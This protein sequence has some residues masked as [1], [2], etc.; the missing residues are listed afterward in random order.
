MR[1]VVAVALILGLIAGHA[2]GP[3]RAASV[4]VAVLGEQFVDAAGQPVFVVGANYE[5]PADRAWQMWDEG[6]FDAELIARDFERARA[7]DLTVLRVFVQQSLANDVRAGRWAKLDRVLELADG[8]GLKL[9][10]TFAD[11]PEADPSRLAAVDA[12]VAARY[13]GRPTIFAYDLKNEPRFGDL[14]LAI[15]PVDMTPPLQ[16][17]RLVAAVGETVPRPEIGEYRRSEQ[18]QRDIP[19]RLSDDQ[20]YVYANALA[21]YRQFLQ[22][23]QA[24]ARARGDTTAGYMLSR[25]S[26]TW[27]A[28]KEALNG[29]FAAWLTPQM[30]AIRAVDPDR[31]IAV[32]HVDAVIASLPVNDWLDYRALH[33][34]PS[35]S[36]EGIRLSMAVFD[37]VRAAVPGKPLVLGEF[38]FSNATVDEESG[39]ALEADMVRVACNRGGA[40]VLKWMLNDFPAGANPREN[41]F[42]MYRGDG[43]A[44]PVVA[45]LRGL[46]SLTPLDR[47]LVGGQPRPADYDVCGGH[48][49]TQASQAGDAG[50]AGGPAR[51][52]AG[53]TITNDD[54]MP[55]WDAYRQLGGPPAL[56][57]PIGRRFLLDGVVVQPM[58][59]VILE[60]RPTERQI[61]VLNTFERLR[62]AGRDGWLESERQIPPALDWSAD[63]GLPWERLLE[64]RL[65]LLDGS[66][67]LKARY[68]A[69][70]DWLHRLGLPVSVAD[71][72]DVQVVRAERAVLQ[73]WKRA[74][75]WAQ[76]G[77][78]TVANAGEI[79]RDAGL[80]PSWVSLPELAP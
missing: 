15:Y 60:W 66:Q 77:E 48:F 49:F 11:Y 71:Y 9:I 70:P 27:Y 23:A 62:E 38:G 74:V 18:G 45:A 64:R 54:G 73:Q 26:D 10:L 19:R 46:A 51:S 55:F 63:A 25:D 42:G 24:W 7:A 40:G 20:A 52:G 50:A 41:N 35:A 58:Q 29:T 21:A 78:I 13:R 53:Y 12:A 8:Y 37:D 59:K 1:R 28:L 2:A 3:A 68:M 39:A 76:A 75:P 65:A 79:A 80:F 72:P 57:F 44:K 17:S 5:G 4:P 32:G 34:Y 43:S 22:D 30:A 61:G 67:S 31:L 14:A 16:D 69:E 6:R 47:P 56:G 36:S 33:L